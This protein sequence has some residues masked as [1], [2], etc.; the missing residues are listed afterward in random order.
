MSGPMKDFYRY[1]ACLMEPWDGP[2][3][4]VFTD[5]RV[6]GGVLDRNGLRPS[7]ISLT[8]DGLVVLASE[9]GVLDDLDP[10]DIVSKRRLEPG[11][12]F[13]VDLEAGAIIDDARLKERMAGAQPTAIGW[14][15]T[16]PLAALLRRPCPRTGPRHLLKRQIAF[17]YT[18]RT[19]DR[20]GPMALDGVEAV[21]SMGDDTP[22]PC[23]ARNRRSSSATSSRC[24]PR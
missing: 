5:G 15:R 6:I 1:H 24:S 10:A 20:D 2:A 11:R 14:R 21:G 13:L 12:M 9:T 18:T 8:R 3:D 19:E 17:G 4:V 22:W 7:R 23:S 16:G